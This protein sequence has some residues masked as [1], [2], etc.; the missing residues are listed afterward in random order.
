MDAR[1]CVCVCE[2]EWYVGD[3]TRVQ[4]IIFFIIEIELVFFIAS[5]IGLSDTKADWPTPLL[6]SCVKLPILN[7]TKK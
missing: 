4:S 5:E 7:E 2:G 6:S 3:V 1:A